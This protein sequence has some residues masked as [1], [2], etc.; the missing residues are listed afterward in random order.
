MNQQLQH[1]IDVRINRRGVVHRRDFLR[2]VTAAAAAGSTTGWTRLSAQA[3]QLRQQGMACIVL[4]MQGGPS[5]FETLSPLPDHP[6]GG[7][8]KSIATSVAGIQVSENLPHVAGVMDDLCLIR[9]MT[10]KEGSHP[11]AS[12]LMHTGYLP[13]ASVKYPE[14]GSNVGHQLGNAQFELPSYVRIGRGR[15]AHGGGF[16]GVQYDP[17]V[18]TAAGRLPDNSQLAT[19][20]QRYRRRLRLLEG[21]EKQFASRGGQQEVANHATL[22]RQ[23]ADMVTSKHMQAFNLEGEPAAMHAAYGDSEFA[24]G[25]LLARRL[26]ETGVTFVEVTAGN[27]DA[28]PDNFTQSKDLCGR[29]EFLCPRFNQLAVIPLPSFVD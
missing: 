23:A 28:H 27:W 9:S 25:C 29:I 1:Q 6:N 26:V 24:K 8:T 21:M 14:L 5:Q 20:A 22:Y 3:D 13:T 16:L 10:G 11:R 12:F 18:V 7:E 19:D 17:F 15:F 4:W 2:W